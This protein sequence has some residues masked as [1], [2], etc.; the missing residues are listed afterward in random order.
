[1]QEMQASQGE[2]EHT[3][4]V[5]EQGDAGA[6]QSEGREDVVVFFDAVLNYFRAGQTPHE[7]Q[8][9]E[10]HAHAHAHA[11]AEADQVGI[12]PK[13]VTDDLGRHIQLEGR[14]V[15]PHESPENNGYEQENRAAPRQ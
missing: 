1:M 6:L 8:H 4:I 3:K 5:A 12:V 9:R 7:I 15:V 13:V 10:T 2:I 14:D 11:H